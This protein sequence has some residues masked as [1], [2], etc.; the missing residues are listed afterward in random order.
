[1]S[2]LPVE[3]R[4]RRP[5]VKPTFSAS[6]W[7]VLAVVC[8]AVFVINASTMIVAIAMPPISLQLGASTH[9]L[10]WIVDAF[11]LTFAAF[12]LA[13]G[14]IADRVGRRRSLLFGLALFATASLI[15]S[16][17]SSP[18]ELIT[19]RAIAG[20]GAA[21]IYPVTLSVVV[22]V[23]TERRSRSIAIGIWTATS[24][25]AIGTGFP[26]GGYLVKHYWWGSSIAFMGV[27]AAV[28]LLLV[29]MLVPDSRDPQVPPLDVAGLVLSTLGFGMLVF[30]IIEAPELGWGSW[31]CLLGFA[32]AFSVLV[33]FVWW[34]RRCPHPMLDV[35]LFANLRFSAASLAVTTAFF[36]A[37]GFVFV[38]MQCFQFVYGYGS[39]EAGTRVLPVAGA[40][41]VASVVGVLLALKLGNKLVV[42][43]GLLLFAVDFVWISTLSTQTGYAEIAG[44]MVL[45]GTALGFSSAPATEA[46]MGVVPKEKAGVGSA[47]NDATRELGGTLGVAIIGSIALSI[48]R[49]RMAENGLGAEA[50]A[51]AQESM[52]GAF[53]LAAGLAAGGDSAAAERLIGLTRLDFLAGVSVGC[54]VAAG[55]CLVGALFVAAFLPAHPGAA[56]TERAETA[57]PEGVLLASR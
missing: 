44:Q 14:N 46:I 22:N 39:F 43:T 29:F 1:M 13:M 9:D 5:L 36:A 11:N 49:N 50:T 6:P 26:V 2:N 15:G 56:P 27:V 53:Q 34:E 7:A 41:A 47:V 45:F 51:S 18:G 42:A 32:N 24:G 35:S 40:T 37:F 10:L 17:A 28:G 23:F 30:T 25:A 21:V 3:S 48:Y 19:W 55:V 16:Q 38:I 31:R 54:L 57:V 4:R 20:F 33:A 52:A 8:L 12:V